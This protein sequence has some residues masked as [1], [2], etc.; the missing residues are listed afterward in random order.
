MYAR[1]YFILKVIVIGTLS[2]VEVK[3]EVE[4]RCIV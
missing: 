1:W 2:Y 4:G 3:V